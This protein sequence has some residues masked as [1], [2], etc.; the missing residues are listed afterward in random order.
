MN[1]ETFY[2]HEGYKQGLIDGKRTEGQVKEKYLKNF[3]F[4]N[5]RT[6]FFSIF[7]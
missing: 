4:L 5:F 7:L 6:I 3:F 2:R 1:R